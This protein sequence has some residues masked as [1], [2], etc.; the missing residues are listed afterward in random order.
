MPTFVFCIFTFRSK[1]S[2]D[3]LAL[4]ARSRSRIGSGYPTA[5]DSDCVPVMTRTLNPAVP[6]RGPRLDHAAASLIQK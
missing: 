6:K 2:Q 1:R 4:N 3:R 5:G